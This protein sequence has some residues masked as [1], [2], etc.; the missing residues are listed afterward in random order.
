[1]NREVLD[2]RFQVDEILSKSDQSSVYRGRDL[3]TDEAVVVRVLKPTSA[4]SNELLQ[5]RLQEFRLLKNLNHP[6][7]VRVIQAGLTGNNLFYLATEFIPG[8]VLA[9]IVEEEGPLDPAT[10]VYYIDQIASVLDSAHAQ[11]II[12]RDVGP[13]QVMVQ[14]DHTVKLLGFSLAK[15]HGPDPHAGLNVTQM[16]VAVGTP[17]YMSPEQ[18]LGRRVTKLSDVYALGCTSFLL[19]TG[20][21]PFDGKNDLQTMLAHVKSPIPTFSERN[22]AVSVPAMVEE[23]VRR[24]M[25]KEPANRPRSAGEFARWLHEA[26]TD[27]SQLP[28]GFDPA[29]RTRTPLAMAS[30]ADISVTSV[31]AREVEAAHTTP[32]MWTLVALGAA[33]LGAAAGAVWAVFR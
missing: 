15:I 6:N 5:R 22:P 20:R 12:H 33:G 23:V 8:R 31:P 18:A 3:K 32:L 1:M 28:T 19:L 17:Q 4:D 11:G 26:I 25:D 27:P 10:A 14:D 24:A 9:R 16:G 21:F 13:H 30:S 7:A 2:G 29:P